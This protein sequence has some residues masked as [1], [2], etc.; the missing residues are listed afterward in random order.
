VK[1]ETKKAFICLI[2]WQYHVDADID[3]TRVY[4]SVAAMTGPR[5]CADSCGIAEVELRI[6]RIAVKPTSQIN[7]N[8]S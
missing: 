5:R 3:G 1:R 6:K 4:P 2:D 7:K 8:K